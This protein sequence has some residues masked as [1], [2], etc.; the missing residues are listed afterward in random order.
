P[1]ADDAP[2]RDL[3]K[4]TEESVRRAGEETADALRDSL[5]VEFEKLQQDLGQ[6]QHAVTAETERVDSLRREIE[7]TSAQQ[8]QE[9]GKSREELKQAAQEALFQAREQLGSELRVQLQ[10]EIEDH[11]QQVRAATA[12]MD[13]K[14]AKLQSQ[15]TAI[16]NHP[17][18][19]RRARESLELL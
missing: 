18:E 2:L 7:A 19:A 3:A 1:Q 10:G 9:A 15:I 6:A 11:R 8:R 16:S 17:E 12:A 13:D 5:R 4:L 14:A